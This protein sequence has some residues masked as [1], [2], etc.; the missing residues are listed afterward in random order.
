MPEAIR[1]AAFC[2]GVIQA[3]ARAGWLR[4]VDYLSTVSGGGYCGGMFG[5]LVSLAGLA[6]AQ[7]LLASNDSPVLAWLRRN[8]RYLTPSGSRDAHPASTT[9]TAASASSRRITTASIPTP[10]SSWGRTDCPGP[11]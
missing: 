9:I 7:A 6:G 4:R 11:P 1:S 5:R 8:G 3:L 10:P 2:L